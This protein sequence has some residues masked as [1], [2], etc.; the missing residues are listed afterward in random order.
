MTILFWILLAATAGPLPILDEVITIPPLGRRHVPIVLR[1]R[2][3]EVVC[4]FSVISGG[5]S[6]RLTLVGPPQS[7]RRAR[8]PLADTG[9]KNSDILRYAVR[10]PGN[11]GVVLESAPGNT[12]PVAVRLKVTL[13]FTEPG[14]AVRTLPPERRLLIVAISLLGFVGIVVWAGRKLLRA[15]RQQRNDE[16][17]PPL[18]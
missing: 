1:Q 3:A 10:E 2:P 18:G 17:S 4:S 15:M 6:A 7:R 12:G 11:Y 5:A 9:Y 14:E 8:G 16:P 13:V